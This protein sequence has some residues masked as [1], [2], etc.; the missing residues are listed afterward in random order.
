MSHPVRKLHYRWI[1]PLKVQRRLGPGTLGVTVDVRG[2]VHGGFS[3]GGIAGPGRPGAKSAE[4]TLHIDPVRAE[5][6]WRLLDDARFESMASETLIPMG[7]G[8]PIEVGREVDGAMT[9]KVF[10]QNKTPPGMEAFLVEVR[11][12]ADELVEHPS[13]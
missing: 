10:V 12:L 1:A 6:L 7:E 3:P 13:P 11:A 4:F 8:E 5:H 2:S 9:T